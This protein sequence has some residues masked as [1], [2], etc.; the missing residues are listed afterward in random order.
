[1]LFPHGGICSTLNKMKKSLNHSY[2][3]MVCFEKSH[4]VQHVGL[5]LGRFF[6]VDHAHITHGRCSIFFIIQVGYYLELT[7]GS[8]HTLAFLNKEN[9]TNYAPLLLILLCVATSI[10]SQNTLNTLVERPYSPPP[11]SSYFQPNNSPF[12]K[13]ELDKDSMLIWIGIRTA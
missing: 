9:S 8:M 2:Q 1:M 10:T 11:Q 6:L 3:F 7:W 12:E 4:L 5:Y 13:E